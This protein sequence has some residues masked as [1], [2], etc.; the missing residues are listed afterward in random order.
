MESLE[1]RSRAVEPKRGRE[2]VKP[3]QIPRR[4]WGDILLRVKDSITVN[5]VGI[6]ASGVAF[7]AILAIFPALAA[8]VSIY[9]LVADPA[10]IQQ[11]FSEM[12]G[13]VPPGAR[14]LLVSQLKMLASGDEA[15]LT[16]GLIGSI[17]LSLWS[18]SKAMSALI[19]ALNIV[20]HEEEKRGLIKPYLISLILT[21]GAIL[22]S[23]ATLFLIVL[24]PA[25]LG[26]LG[27]PIALEILIRVV[28]WVLLVIAIVLGLSFVYRYAPSRSAAQ[29]QWISPG[30][31]VGAVLWL[32]GSALF[33]IYVENFGNYD[34][35]Y[36]TFGTI[37]ILMLWFNLSAYAT[38]IG[39]EINAEMEHQTGQDTTTGEPR[40]QGERGAYVADH[41]GKRR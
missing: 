7:Y 9:G 19:T 39:A 6:V 31:V 8:L 32:A 4:G 30:A 37:I 5:A 29:W 11:Q 34:K 3:G 12:S 18:A 13:A 24:V 15:A 2:A 35:T 17:V 41:L 33:S 14:E 26:Y 25:A 21:F 27:V 38:L 1:D 36:G 10:Q 23:I 28:R 40:V 20:Y 16:A 22:F